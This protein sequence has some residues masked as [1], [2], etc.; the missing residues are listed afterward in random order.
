M[1]TRLRG[2]DFALFCPELGQDDAGKLA[3]ELC[4]LWPVYWTMDLSDQPGLGHIGI[5]PFQSGDQLGEV[6]TRASDSLTLA[7][8]QP[9]NSWCMDQANAPA[10]RE[11]H[12]DWK[13][14]LEAACQD[15]SLRLRWY[16]VCDPDKTVLWH[17]GM[18]FGHR[19][20]TFRPWAR[21]AWCHRRHDWGWY[22]GWTSTRC[23]WHCA[24]ARPATGRQHV[25]GLLAASG[26]PAGH[27][28]VA[29]ALSGTPDQFEF[30]E[31]GLDEH[32]EHF[33]AFSRAIRP[34]GHQLAVE[35]QGHNMALV[36]RTHEASISYLVLDSTLT[37]G[38]HADEGRAALLRGL[39]RMAALM[40]VRWKPRASA[41][42]KMPR[43]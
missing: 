9:L 11:A 13:S 39:L 34:A 38:I 40:G 15:D 35:I 20:T 17:E 16:P 6:L 32:W 22:T 28:A 14:L 5:T 18:L 8:A 1:A 12:P 7:E 19:K 33:V 43:P 30:H 4:L 3:D 27:P 2:A 31:T 29:A 42:P 26:I 10:S 24:T 36:A 37:Q 23:S 41:M 25:T 21:C